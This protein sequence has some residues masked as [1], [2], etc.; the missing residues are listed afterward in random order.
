MKNNIY[1][2][3][4]RGG[5]LLFPENSMEAYKKSAELGVNAVECDV[6]LT[7]DNKLVIM[8]DENLKRITGIDKNISELT[9]NEISRIKLSNGE[10]IPSLEDVMH[11][12]DITLIIELKGK[13]VA[14]ALSKLFIKKPELI[15]K[16]AVISFF[17]E[18]ILEIK[19]H[20]QEIVTGALIAGFPVDP[21]YMAK[22]CKADIISLNFEGINKEYVNKCQEGNIKVAVWT[23]NT[24]NEI[25]N[26]IDSGVDII[27]SDRPDIVMKLIK[28]F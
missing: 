12:V 26:C 15:K 16:C 5:S 22:S 14:N 19:E 1:V 11:N 2:I 7:R 18:A 6:H 13:D 17:H 23:P 4:H 28:K 10:N 25:Q 27:A 3:A 20:F 24:E 8:H 9:Y 21:V